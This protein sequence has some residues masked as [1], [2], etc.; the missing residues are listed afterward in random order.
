MAQAHSQQRRINHHSMNSHNPER[1]A[2]HEIPSEAGER[3]LTGVEKALGILSWTV[4]VV[5]MSIMT[6]EHKNPPPI[7]SESGDDNAN[8]VVVQKSTE[9]Y[10]AA[11]RECLAHPTPASAEALDRASYFANSE[12]LFYQPNLMRDH[13]HA[14]RV[15]VSGLNGQSIDAIETVTPQT[16]VT[17]RASQ[18]IKERETA[19]T[20]QAAG[21]GSALE[22]HLENV[23]GMGENLPTQFLP[24]STEK[25]P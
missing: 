9:K 12:L 1:S 23:Y 6:C 14:L 22:E 3:N 25:T 4:L 13:Y 2:E 15:T 11:L 5:A 24:E 19:L 18:L 7:S 16:P 21:D 20:L 10:R 17:L 8:L